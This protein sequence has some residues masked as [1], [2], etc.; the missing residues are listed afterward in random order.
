MTRFQPCLLYTSKAKVGDIE[1]YLEK[2]T[3]GLAKY[4]QQMAAA[5]NQAADRFWA[6]RKE[7]DE[8]I[9]SLAPSQKPVSINMAVNFNQPVQSPIEV[10]RELN[11]VS[12]EMARRIGG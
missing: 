12:E 7:Y 3:S 1:A 10:R 4:Q 5:A 8:H 11:R 9:S 6:S 2:L